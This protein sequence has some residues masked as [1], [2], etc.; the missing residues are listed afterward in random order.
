MVIQRWAPFGEMISL[1]DAMDSLLQDTFIRP[2]SGLA[3]GGRPSGFPL[4][5]RETPDEFVVTASL[6]GVRPEDIQVTVHGDSVT[7]IGEVKGEQEKDEGNRHIRERRF[8]MARRSLTLG[9]SIDPEKAQSRFED[10]VLTLVLP[11]AEQA[12]PKQIKV[13]N[14][15]ALG[16]AQSIGQTSAAS[17]GGGQGQSAGQTQATGAGKSK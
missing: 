8:G 11:K 15:S 9:T 2:G 7:I 3:D 16:Q 1:R 10:G 4:D 6:P 12:K 17:Q 13:G 14:G 5:V